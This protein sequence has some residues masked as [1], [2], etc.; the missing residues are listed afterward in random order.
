MVEK[1]IENGNIQKLKEAKISRNWKSRLWKS[2]GLHVAAMHNQLG[3]A[4]FFLNKKVDI[5]A[6]DKNG[7]TPLH[8]ASFKNYEMM[9]FLLKNGADPNIKDNEGNTPLYNAVSRYHIGGISLLLKYG[10]DP[11]VKNKEGLK[12]VEYSRSYE[13]NKVLLKAQAEKQREKGC[14]PFSSLIPKKSKMKD[15]IKEKYSKR[16]SECGDN[17]HCVERLKNP[18]TYISRNPHNKSQYLAYLEVDPYN[19]GFLYFFEEKPKGQWTN[20]FKAPRFSRFTMQYFVGCLSWEKSSKWSY[21]AYSYY[22]ERK[23]FSCH[24]GSKENTPSCTSKK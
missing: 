12:P 20:W 22:G 18:K 4:R 23:K 8:L 1:W 7:W 15:F 9:E 14:K 6:K 21:E 10:A 17:K 19:L 16:L 24:L 5:N 13:I 2:S 3:S 11:T